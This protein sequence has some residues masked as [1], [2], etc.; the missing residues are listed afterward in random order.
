MHLAPRRLGRFDRPQQGFAR[1]RTVLRTASPRA[2]GLDPAP[3][4]RAWQTI[5]GHEQ[6]QPGLP[7]LFPG[8]V[9]TYGHAGRVVFSEASGHARLYADGEGALLPEDQRIATRTDTI[10]DLASISK[11]FTSLVVLQ[12]VERGRVDLDAPVV[13]HLPAFAEGAGAGG[14]KSEVTVRQLLT[15]TSGFPPFLLFWRDQPDPASRLRAALTADLVHPPGS[16]YLYSDLNLIALGVLVHRVSGQTLDEAVTAGITRPLGLRDTGYTPDPALRPR[17]A[18]TEH[19]AVPARGMVWGEVHDENAWSFGGV[20]GHAGVFSTAAD[21]AV[22]AQT[23]LNGGVYGRHRILS[24]S[25]VR[26][27]LTDENAAFA[28]DAH[29]LGFELDQRWY[30]GGLSSTRTAGHTGYTGTSLV[31]DFASRS[32][33]ILLTNRVHPTRDGGSVN[34]ARAA[35]AQG[36]ASALAVRPRAGRDAWFSGTAGPRRASLAAAVPATTGAELRFDQLVDLGEQDGLTLEV[37]A[38]GGTTW[39]ALPHRLDGREVS[40]PYRSAGVRRWQRARA[41]LPAGTSHVRW[42]YVQATTLSGRGAYLD[43]LRVQAGRRRLLDLEHQ[44]G[45]LSA[46]GWTLVRR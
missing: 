12:Q 39:S 31:I 44:P 26:Q 45:L 34:P 24:P 7:P 4:L 9:L 15:H 13:R 21:L 3:L 6:P 36:M 16:T 32:F 38:D 8:A 2:V 41:A 23:L 14:D 30:M 20:A 35:A 29:G 1:P 18:A 19:Q 22:L 42:T 37:S 11:L 33:V 17:I 28:G 46:D 5:T 25:S 40:G 10:F 27:M 43:G